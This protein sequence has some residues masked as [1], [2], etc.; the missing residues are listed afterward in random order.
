LELEADILKKLLHLAA[1]QGTESSTTLAGELGVDPELVRQ[2]LD[3][4]TRL[5]YIH[6]V[7]PGCSKPCEGC[8]LQSM[9][10]YR[11]QPRI[12]LLTDKG[13]AYLLKQNLSDNA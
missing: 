6:A 9:C 10:L 2:M 4:L 12:W 8:P 3:E 1:G 7:V 5:G 13:E 11:R